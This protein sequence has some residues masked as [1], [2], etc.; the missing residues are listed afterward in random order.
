MN[1]KRI[2]FVIPNHPPTQAVCNII[3]SHRTQMDFMLMLFC[4]QENNLF[5]KAPG[6]SHQLKF[7]A[8]TQIMSSK[9]TCELVQCCTSFMVCHSRLKFTLSLSNV[10]KWEKGPRAK[11]F[12]AVSHSSITIGKPRMVELCQPQHTQHNFGSCSN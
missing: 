5:P 3:Q 11:I 6:Y 12:K 2:S 10:T 4:R 8:T 1:F 9:G 7:D